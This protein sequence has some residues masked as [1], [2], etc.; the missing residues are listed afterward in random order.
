M[1]DSEVSVRRSYFGVRVSTEQSHEAVGV[2][3]AS[4][5]KDA[6]LQLLDVDNQKLVDRSS[7]RSTN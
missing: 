7:S 3:A 2:V 5:E 6:Y 1:L 4:M